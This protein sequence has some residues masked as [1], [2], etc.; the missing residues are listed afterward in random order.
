M[1]VEGLS[2]YIWY[3]QYM[4][5]Y[6]VCTCPEMFRAEKR[7]PYAQSAQTRSLN[8]ARRKA[9]SCAV[10]ELKWKMR[11][12]AVQRPRKSRLRYAFS[13]EK[14]GARNRVA[15]INTYFCALLKFSSVTAEMFKLY[16]FLHKNTVQKFRSHRIDR[17]NRL[18]PKIQKH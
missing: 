16:L 12:I 5:L 17:K 4:F 8:E 11:D 18:T 13:R 7:C 1:G 6:T 10:R 2:F 9:C 14:S 15:R 3:V